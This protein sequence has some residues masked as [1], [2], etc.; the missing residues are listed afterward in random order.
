MNPAPAVEALCGACGAGA[1]LSWASVA[2]AAQLF[3]PTIRRTSDPSTM[4]ITFDD[5][6]NPA[7]TPALL[8]LLDRHQARATFFLIGRNVRRFPDL[9][10]EIAK[11]GH[12]IGNHTE[13]HP[14]LT[15]MHPRRI[16]DQLARC[17][18]AIATAIGKRPRWMRPPY[19]FRGPQLNRIVRRE[20]VG[21]V[22]WSVLAWDWKP[23]PAAPVIR[24]L[25]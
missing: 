21:V 14:S 7:V 1:F 5:G 3:G 23:Q 16:A 20:S 10:R 22:M 12:T 8:D 11:R 18:E 15:F 13:T 9:T 19:G 25:R 6:P 2:P 24:R 17:D 4:A